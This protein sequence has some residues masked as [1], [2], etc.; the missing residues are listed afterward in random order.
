MVFFS[1]LFVLRFCGEVGAVLGV[2]LKKWKLQAVR[3]LAKG[4]TLELGFKLR[5]R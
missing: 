3:K 5:S 2:G 4:H 1:V